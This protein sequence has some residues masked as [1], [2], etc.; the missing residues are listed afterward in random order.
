[1]Q[2]AWVLCALG[3]LAGLGLGVYALLRPRA[4]A[5]SLG[6]AFDPERP[7]AMGEV[8]AFGAFIA[9]AQLLALVFVVGALSEVFGLRSGATAQVS[10]ILLIAPAAL[11]W[12]CAG[13]ARIAS[14]LIDKDGP[15]LNW[16]LAFV[17]FVLALMIAMPWATLSI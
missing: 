9:G 13:F 15:A 3:L 8:R 1:M 7:G 14:I 2:I 10:A 12:L 6:F 17:D 16:R 11:V 5:R 4:V